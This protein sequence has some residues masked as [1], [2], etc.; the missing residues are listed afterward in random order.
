MKKPVQGL[1]VPSFDQLAADMTSRSELARRGGTRRLRLMTL[2]TAIGLL[3]VTSFVL[4]S[5]TAAEEPTP[6]PKSPEESAACL[7]FAEPGLTVE[8][9]A[10]EPDVVSPVAMAWDA[11]GRLFVAE[12]IDYPVGP[13]RGRIRL[14]T[15]PDDRG[16]YRRSQVF[17]DEL[18]FP[19]SVLPWRDGLLVA[20]APNIL[21]LRDTDGDGRCDETRV[22]LTGFAE[23][24]QQ[25]RV[26]GLTYGLDHWVYGA[27]GRSDG[28]VRRPDAPE[29]QAVSI[30][31]RDFRFQPDTGTVEALVG[32][33]QFGLPRD[34]WGNRFPSWNTI[35]LRHV[36]LEEP[37]GSAAAEFDA[38]S[39]V[40][41]IVDPGDDGRVFS[42]SPKPKTFNAESTEYY[43]AMCGLTIYRGD[44]L[45]ESLRGQAFVGESLTNL[46]HRRVLEPHGPTFVARRVEQNREFL[47]SRDGWFHPVNYATG[48]DGALYIADFYRRFV[49]HP[50]F[51][52]PHLRESQNWREGSQHGRI[53]R[54]VRKDRPIDRQLP[55]LATASVSELVAALRHPNGWRRD[56]AQRLLIERQ[57]RQAVPE[58]AAMLGSAE[59]PPLARLHALWTLAGL[60]ALEDSHLERALHD[61][62]AGVRAAAVRLASQRAGTSARLAR[63][64]AAQINDVDAR[65]R[66]DIAQT[67]TTADPLALTVEERRNALAGLAS[68]PDADHWLFDCLVML[69]E[70]QATPLLLTLMKSPRNWLDR[71]D[72]ARSR[73]LRTLGRRSATAGAADQKGFATV[74]TAI[75]PELRTPGGIELLL[76]INAGL[77]QR[78]IVLTSWLK[79]PPAE[80]ADSLRRIANEVDQ[81]ARTEISSTSPDQLALVEIRQLVEPARA[82]A[83]LLSLLLSPAAVR[84]REAAVNVLVGW[85]DEASLAALFAE[86]S[87]YAPSTRQVIVSACLRSRAATTLLIDNLEAGEINPLEIDQATRFALTQ[88]PEPTLRG[89]ATTVLAATAAADRQPVIDAYQTVLTLEGNPAEGAKLFATHCAV[90]HRVR[91]IGQLVG[92]DLSSLFTRPKASLLVDVLDPSR[93]VSADF[94]NYSVVTHA[95]RVYVGLMS[96]ETAGAVTLKRA[97]G[98]TDTIP[99]AEIAELRASGK[100]LMP[101]GFEQR[102]TPQGLAHVLEFLYHPD[103]DAL[104]AALAAP[105]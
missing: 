3:C 16:R 18:P 5:T 39:A 37:R 51:V 35:P 83:G 34:D 11:A 97:E 48:P 47:A 20:S 56:T 40:A 99:R 92:P 25:L 61:S 17:A 93:Q 76:G 89:R 90:C 21:F 53:W 79:E 58:L 88:Y 72:A 95:G 75:A 41:K 44:A 64:L 105:R 69:R 23:G 8:L 101:D 38:E 98:A 2:I 63:A 43:N 55:K 31:R 54:V 60:G 42:I 81:L 66:L 52:A 100:S 32:F 1:A 78:G 36:V 22:V 62:H 9:V 104:R 24:N 29:D 15:E 70:D 49:E 33:S 50:Q 14:L 74:L 30:R 96:S 26:N 94:I 45:G 102:L 73:F 77:A 65:V 19:T 86:W 85:G 10:C 27:N 6:G 68:H 87:Q 82:R 67:L 12:M 57:G 13:M 4:S 80:L 71:P 103:L 7:E 91:G 46:V 28:A 59:G 84:I